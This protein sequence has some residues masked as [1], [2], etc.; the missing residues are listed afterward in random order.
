MKSIR[1]L[2]RL[3]VFII[4]FLLLILSFSVAAQDQNQNGWLEGTVH[5]SDG[6]PKEVILEVFR[7]G[8]E[9]ADKLSD[10]Y[11]DGFFEIRDVKPGVYEIRV[12]LVGKGWR[13][14]RIFGVAIKPGIRS[15]LNIVLNEGS[16]IEEIGQ[17]VVATQ[18]VIKISQELT[19]MQKE[20]DE[21]KSK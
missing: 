6:N 7:N 4:P 20:I 15:T 11:M 14:Q 10:G 17:P 9:V 8:K 2:K 19:R 5:T 1:T 3:Y 12:K 21:L 13:P 16:G 18:P